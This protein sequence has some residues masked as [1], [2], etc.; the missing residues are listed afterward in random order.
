M[1]HQYKVSA[2]NGHQSVLK[3]GENDAWLGLEIL[4]LA[5]GETWEGEA[6][7]QEA[8]LIPLLGRFTVKIS[9]NKDAGWKGVGGRADIFSAP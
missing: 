1:I 5:P 3:V 7:E 9:G 2:V 4:R 6:G 8:A